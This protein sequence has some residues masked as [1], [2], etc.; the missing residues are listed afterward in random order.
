M[1]QQTR[2]LCG[3]GSVL[4]ACLGRLALSPLSDH[5][6]IVRDDGPLQLHHGREDPLHLQGVSAQDL[7]SASTGPGRAKWGWHGDR[8][9]LCGNSEKQ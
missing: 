9:G 8:E 7:S 1:I 4:D 6:P 2:V 5:V 3:L